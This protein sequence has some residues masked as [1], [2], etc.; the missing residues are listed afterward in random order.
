MDNAISPFSPVSLLSG[1]GGGMA[2]V[3]SQKTQGGARH[4][5]GGCPITKLTHL[6]VQQFRP[7]QSGSYKL[8]PSGLIADIQTASHPE[9]WRPLK[10]PCESISTM[11]CPASL[12]L[13]AEPLGGPD[14]ID[15]SASNSTLPLLDLEHRLK[16]E[17]LALADCR[18]YAPTPEMLKRWVAALRRACALELPPDQLNHRLR[19][20]VRLVWQSA[21]TDRDETQ[22]V[23][24][25]VEDLDQGDLVNII[26]GQY[27][28]WRLRAPMATV[29]QAVENL[30]E[31]Q[32]LLR[33]AER[34]FD[35]VDACLRPQFSEDRYSVVKEIR[36]SD[37]V[38]S[39]LRESTRWHHDGAPIYITTLNTWLGETTIYRPPLPS[40]HS[41]DARQSHWNRAAQ[42]PTNTVLAFHG[43]RGAN[44]LWHRSPKTLA[45]R[46][47]LI[48]RI[49]LTAND[50]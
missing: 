20:A 30:P 13:F 24:G 45:P 6:G 39:V 14:E 5:L 23:A 38:D 2:F 16:T 40:D 36:Y 46:L 32:T 48:Y 25:D 27:S 50:F 7:F 49:I 4:G 18:D 29:R 33:F 9:T 34:Y 43:Q 35:A 21:D 12:P 8:R 47:L 44:P 42:P 37:Q 17:G 31:A 41:E 1:P 11:R 26:D 22:K 10:Q 19:P 15:A 3:P 28:K